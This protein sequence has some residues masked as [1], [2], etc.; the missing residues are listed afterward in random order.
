MD[1]GGTLRRQAM[2]LAWA[3]WMLT[4]ALGTA[5]PGVGATPPETGAKLPAAG[6]T[7]PAGG[8]APSVSGAAPRAAS[9]AESV[10]P[11]H[12]AKTAA[13]ESQLLSVL[14]PDAL[15]VVYV[16]DALPALRWLV[17]Y[18]SRP[19]LRLLAGVRELFDSTPVRRGQQFLAY[20]EKELG[21]PWPECVDQL[22]GGGLAL[23]INRPAPGQPDRA[24]LAI[25][26]RQPELAAKALRLFIRLAEA[27]LARQ[28]SKLRYTYEL[29]DG[30]R[31][32]RLGED[33]A[34]AEVDGLFLASNSL[35]QVKDALQRRRDASRPS[36][37]GIAALR[38]ARQRL[39][40][41]T[42]AWAWLHLAEAKKT[43]D[44]NAKRLLEVPTSDLL[45]H[46]LLGGLLD[47][48][49]R[50]DWLAVALTVQGPELMLS[51][52]MP[53]GVTGMSVGGQAHS[54]AADEAGLYPF[55]WP[56]DAVYVASF[57][58]APYLFWEHR[59]DF[60]TP[61]LRKDIEEAER[62]SGVVLLGR[63]LSTVLR[64]L[65][66]R[67]QVI[68]TRPHDAG[69]ELKPKQR[70]PAFAVVLE[71]REP[72]TAFAH[73][74]PLLRAGA[75]LGA[76]NVS[77]RMKEVSYREVPIVTYRFNETDANYAVDHGLLFNFT[78]SFARVGQHL[79]VASSL[80]LA[81]SLI[82]QALRAEPQSNR[83]D[84]ASSRQRFSFAGLRQFL[85][86][87]RPQAETQALLQSGLPPD[88]ARQEFERLLQL[89]DQLGM[90]ELAVYYEPTGF[91]AEWR[92]TLPAAAGPPP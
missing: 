32:A 29:H 53:A 52:H 68:I 3:V 67:H 42:S 7:P 51:M 92:M 40:H 2:L 46:L 45:P 30:V 38:A 88:E 11:Q 71:L 69:Y 80:E 65:G 72:D 44:E 21:L 22:T 85:T 13:P 91:R 4:A 59:Q 50:S 37:A 6:A 76:L 62:Q 10:S 70:V 16:E 55:F 49:R 12:L 14:P 73:L 56:A 58:W 31:I 77:M 75:F 8:V 89:L 57:M 1:R 36:A 64:C 25:Q 17:Q 84:P 27:E 26:A 82:D 61:S 74:A 34:L 15:V 35:V 18:A 41:G 20:I 81:Q 28:E 54:R 63:R 66:K 83:P 48:V 23:A 5:P 86:V 43:F 60:L 87:I 19:E 47:V 39:P 90:L 33:F 24:L 9:T 78:P 79:I